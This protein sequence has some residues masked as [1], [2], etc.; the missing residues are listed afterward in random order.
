MS[1]ENQPRNDNSFSKF[2]KM[3]AMGIGGT[4]LFVTVNYI[5][6][7]MGYDGGLSLPEIS[8]S[9]NGM[10]LSVVSLLSGTREGIP[11]KDY[12]VIF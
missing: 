10:L 3:L 1:E 5:A 11:G 9:L 4:T 7:Q 6:K 2:E 8:Y 12:T